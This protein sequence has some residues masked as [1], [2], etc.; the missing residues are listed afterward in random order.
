MEL[1]DIVDKRR[2]LRA[3][4]KVTIP[5]DMV[6][7]LAR[8]AGLAPSCFNKQPWR[9]VFVREEGMLDQL[10]GALSRGNKWAERASMIM[11]AVSEPE[12]DCVTGGRE[13]YLFDTGMATAFLL[14]KA[15]EM[16]LVAHP[17]AGFDEE[18]AKTILGV[19]ERMRLITLVI[20][21]THAANPEE[22]LS[23]SQ[24]ERERE[25]PL[26][27]KLAEIMMHERYSSSSNISSE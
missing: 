7:E 20:F 22:L 6:R 11:A 9:F 12:L 25:R 23:E 14:L 3:L 5:D 27:L 13:Y 19:P 26:R 18:K 1:H 8:T 4:E 16:G 21:G 17:I 15:T 24:L 10:H 2:A